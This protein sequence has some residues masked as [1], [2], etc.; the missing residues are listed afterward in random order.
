MNSEWVR[1]RISKARKREAQENRRMLFPIRLVDWDRI[2]E[3]ECFDDTG[4]DSAVEIREYYVPDF[5]LWKTD[6]DKYSEELGK[7]LRALKGRS[8]LQI[9]ES[10]ALSDWTA[11]ARSD[12]SQDRESNRRSEYARA[13]SGAPR[14]R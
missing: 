9:E 1:T 6:H 14:N 10:L 12:R 2:L 8:G 13:Q 5:S 4:K 7:L 3:W 11:G